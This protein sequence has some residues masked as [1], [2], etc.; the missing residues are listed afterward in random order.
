MRAKRF[1]DGVEERRA[2]VRRQEPDSAYR[3]VASCGDRDPRSPK[4][5]ELGAHRCTRFALCVS[6]SATVRKDEARARGYV[7]ND[8]QKCDEPEA[9]ETALPYPPLTEL[10]I[11]VPQG[12]ESL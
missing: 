8:G 9:P 11:G 7:E 4:R 6:P 3:D 2:T 10:F 12:A 5:G 1:V